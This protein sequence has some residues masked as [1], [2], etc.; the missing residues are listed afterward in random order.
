MGGCDTKDPRQNESTYGTETPNVTG[1]IA[2]DRGRVLKKQ[3]S[4]LFVTVM[5]HKK[6]RAVFPNQRNG[7]VVVDIAMRKA[8]KPFAPHGRK[9]GQKVGC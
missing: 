7:S 6:W 5:K 2:Q 9:G 8:I 4:G 1:M 3:K